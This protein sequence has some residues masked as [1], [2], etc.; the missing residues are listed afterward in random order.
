MLD[1]RTT[2]VR[3]SRFT[4]ASYHLFLI[5]TLRRRVNISLAKGE[6]VY[7]KWREDLKLETLRSET[8]LMS[9]RMQHDTDSTP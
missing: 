2:A 7:G 5:A 4:S 8:K 3:C 6:P 1:E 9:A